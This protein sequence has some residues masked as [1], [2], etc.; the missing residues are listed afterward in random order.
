VALLYGCATS[1]RQTDALIKKHPELP[2]SKKIENVPFVKQ[3]KNHCGPATLWMNLK[4]F[5]T[6]IPLEKLSSQMYTPGVKG[7][8]QSE[9][10]SS[11]RSAGY[12]AIP[13]K[14][15]NSL[16]LE[17]SSDH[18][19]IVFQNLGFSFYPKWH[20]ALA[21]GFD[22]N[23]PDIILHTESD[24]YEKDDMRMFERSWNLAGFWG[25]LLLPPGKL[26]KTQDELAHAQ[27]AAAL[28]ELQQFENAE[29]IYQ[30]ILKK[31][32]TNL[33]S[34]IGLGNISYQQKKYKLT[35]NYLKK[36]V[37]FHPQSAMAW[38]NLAYTQ[39][40]MGLTKEARLNAKKALEFAQGPMKDRIRESLKEYL[41]P[42]LD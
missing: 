17:I 42:S 19:V 1:T 31:W 21:V 3:T 22:L 14:D 39:G 33:A 12:L 11:A 36:A 4:Y 30:S 35:L 40:V 13:I 9:M 37:S 26:S 2:T 15:L 16:L 23:G 25:L 29:K 38:H 24:E 7:T 27:G 41:G 34:F 20:Y 6:E 5:K 32:P 10:L 8:F 18:P 28:E